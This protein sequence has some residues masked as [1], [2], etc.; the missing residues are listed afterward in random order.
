MESQMHQMNWFHSGKYSFY[1]WNQFRI[2]VY[3]NLQKS[4]PKSGKSENR[5]LGGEFAHVEYH[6]FNAWQINTNG[7]VRPGDR[8]IFGC[9]IAKKMAI[10]QPFLMFWKF[11]CLVVKSSCSYETIQYSRSHLLSTR[12]WTF[13]RTAWSHR[14][15]RSPMTWSS[16]RSRPKNKTVGNKHRQKLFTGSMIKATCG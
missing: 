15:R 11:F 12:W 14:H 5:P 1:F 9:V 4:P 7:A 13:P 2:L 10:F 6:W 3:S 8:K 16:E